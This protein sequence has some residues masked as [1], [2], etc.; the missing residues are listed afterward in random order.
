[1]DGIRERFDYIRNVWQEIEKDGL[2]DSQKWFVVGFLRDLKLINSCITSLAERTARD[3][4]NANDYAQEVLRLS[5]LKLRLKSWAEPAG[6]E[7]AE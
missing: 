7:D 1:M 2:A 3:V 6:R 5:R 4:E